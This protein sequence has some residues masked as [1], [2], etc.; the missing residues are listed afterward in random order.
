MRSLGG[1]KDHHM[2][3]CLLFVIRIISAGATAPQDCLAANVY[4]GK[5]HQRG[6]DIPINNARFCLFPQ[7]GSQGWGELA[8][9]SKHVRVFAT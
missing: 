3:T 1:F 6:Y 9:S 4:P 2:G 7:A 8:P 5:S